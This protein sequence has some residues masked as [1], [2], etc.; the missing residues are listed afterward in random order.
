M[1]T[2]VS[3]DVEILIVDDLENPLP[4]EQAGR[5]LLRGDIVFKRYYND[6]KATNAA[7]TE[8]G[9]FDTGDLGSIDVNGALRIL[10]RS[11]E[12]IAIN[13]LKYATFELETAIDLELADVVS[14]SYTASFSTV[15]NDNEEEGI[16][17]L[18]S[19]AENMIFKPKALQETIKAIRR[20][21]LQMCSQ[22]P[23][24]VVALPKELLPKSTLGKLSRAKLKERYEA[25]EF[26]D[27]GAPNPRASRPVEVEQISSSVQTVIADS[28]ATITGNPRFSI[29]A[30]SEMHSLGLNSLGYIRLK[31]MLEK[32]LALPKSIPMPLM[33]RSRTLSELEQHLLEL[34]LKQHVYDPVVPLVQTG[35]KT[36]LILVHPGG[37][38]ILI[39]LN[40]LKYL[41]D[42]PIYALR[43][44]GLQEGEDFFHSF[45][46]M[47]RYVLLL[48]TLAFERC[49]SQ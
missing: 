13:G 46:E 39:W 33:L 47:I 5:I 27:F 32:A 18:F 36:P 45:E 4:A 35:S 42:R 17:I 31:R 25:G 48:A 23:H 14:V 44:S 43:V 26:T 38:E 3:K 12:T 29:H 21:I 49:D 20:V 7:M 11:K 28:I 15:V 8:S 24:A 34:G 30:S 22:A 1:G 37:G 41:P 19:P 40:L 2:R 9:W 16:V 6:P 10:G